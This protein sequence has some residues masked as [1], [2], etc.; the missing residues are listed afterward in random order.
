[1]LVI[2]VQSC[3]KNEIDPHKQIVFNEGLPESL[4]SLEKHLPFKNFSYA[5]LDTGTDSL[6]VFFGKLMQGSKNGYWIGIDLQGMPAKFSTVDL[7][8]IDSLG[9]RTKDIDIEF[10]EDMNKISV[11]IIEVDSL[12]LSYAWLDGSELINNISINTIENPLRKNA[13]F[14]EMNLESLYGETIHSSQFKNK[15]V[16]INWWATWCSPCIKEIPGLNGIVERYKLN[17]N[18]RFIA[19]TDDPRSRIERFSGAKVFNYEMAFANEE[20]RNIFG[21]S[22]PINI[23]INPSGIITY[24]SKGAGNNTPNEI[25]ASLQQQLEDYK[26]NLMYAN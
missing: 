16:I 8:E 14:P 12:N 18:I 9:Y 15:F 17:E 7:N 20:V 19:L 10:N 23:I 6:K 2:G 26:R 21:N 5:I 22:Y 4:E 24:I 25:E 11:R 13:L 3:N 1:M